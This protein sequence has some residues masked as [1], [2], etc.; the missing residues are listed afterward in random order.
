[1]GGAVHANFEAFNSHLAAAAQG[2]K[3]N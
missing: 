2:A 1:M 3:R